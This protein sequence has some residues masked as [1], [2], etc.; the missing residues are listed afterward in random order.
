MG[1]GETRPSGNLWGLSWGPLRFQRTQARV[2]LGTFSSFL[3]ASCG[4][5]GIEGKKNYKLCSNLTLKKGP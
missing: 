5:I 3:M 1:G 4:N 2:G